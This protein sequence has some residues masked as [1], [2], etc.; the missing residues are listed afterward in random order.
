MRRFALVLLLLTVLALSLWASYPVTVVDERGRDITLAEQPERVITILPLYAEIALDL[1]AGE[2]V[3]GIADSPNNPSELAHLPKVGTVFAPSAE[4]IVAL[5]P[6]LVLGAFDPVRLTLEDAGLVVFLGG[7]SGGFIDRITETFKLIRNVDLLLW[8]DAE[9][10]DRLIGRLA[11][12]IIAIEERVLDRPRVTVAVLYRGSLEAPPFAPGPNSPEHEIVT[13]TGGLDVFSD[14]TPF[15]GEV[16]IEALLQRDPEVIVT[17]PSQ[18]EFFTRDGR[19]REL[20]AVRTERV[21]GVQASQWVSTRIA[22]TL[23]QVA[24]FLHPEAFAQQP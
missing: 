2:R 3:V 22:Q 18:I 23:E 17:D 5:E 24:Q 12:E 15:G 4:Q 13:R 7:K 1:G 21:F 20:Q 16:S 11:E 19:L 9:R 6:D 10:S 14:I 8:G